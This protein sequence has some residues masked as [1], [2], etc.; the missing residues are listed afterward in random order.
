MIVGRPLRAMFVHKV[1]ELGVLR[2]SRPR[3]WRPNV[4]LVYRRRVCCT[5]KRTGT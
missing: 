1:C 3:I 4:L 2:Q 5:R